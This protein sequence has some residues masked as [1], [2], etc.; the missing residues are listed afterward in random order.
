VNHSL[1]YAQPYIDLHPV[2]IYVDGSKFQEA[3]K[4][5]SQSVQSE[6][7]AKIN[8]AMSGFNVR[9]QNASIDYNKTISTDDEASLLADYITDYSDK[10]SV[11]VS[12]VIEKMSNIIDGHLQNRPLL[13][14]TGN[15]SVPSSIN[16][17]GIT[18]IGYEFQNIGNKAWSGWLNLKLSDEYKKS[19]SVDFAPPQ[20]PV[21]SSGDVVFLSREIKIPKVVYVDGNP[22]SWGKKTKINASIYTRGV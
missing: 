19:V 9:A 11:A 5:F 22:R 3:V 10:L 20:I 17:D 8:D 12:G 7:V 1:D 21:V 14:H 4:S 16:L 13:R 6:V 2:L 15:R 18:V